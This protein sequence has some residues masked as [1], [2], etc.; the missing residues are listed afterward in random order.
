MMTSPSFKSKS[1]EKDVPLSLLHEL[2]ASELQLIY[3]ETIETIKSIDQDIS[4]AESFQKS[5]GISPD[6]DWIHRAK[7]K[8]KIC[9]DFAI[10]SSA[11]LR[12]ESSLSFE[13]A[14]QRRL[15]QILS[16][17]LNP[18]TLAN[19]KKEAHELAL[20]DVERNRS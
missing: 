19:I 2:P 17:E 15:D 3:N 7:K 11:A 14:Y 12:G 5:A 18:T 1:L 6:Q 16:E 9:L 8:R 13:E 4:E 10:K 20:E